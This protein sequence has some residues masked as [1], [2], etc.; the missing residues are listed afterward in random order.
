VLAFL[1]EKPRWLSR[2]PFGSKPLLAHFLL[3]SL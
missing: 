2:E 1:E 3:C